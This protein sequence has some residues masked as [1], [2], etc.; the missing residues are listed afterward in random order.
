MMGDGWKKIRI[1]MQMMRCKILFASRTISLVTQEETCTERVMQQQWSMHMNL[2]SSFAFEREH[3]SSVFF[4]QDASL[5]CMPSGIRTRLLSGRPVVDADGQAESSNKKK[6]GHAVATCC[7][8]N[9]IVVIET[10]AKRP[11]A[12]ETV[13]CWQGRLAPRCQLSRCFQILELVATTRKRT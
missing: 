9:S 11:T 2:D 7:N 12:S 8:R 5:K 4:V 3:F 1:R 6:G 13:V 10:V